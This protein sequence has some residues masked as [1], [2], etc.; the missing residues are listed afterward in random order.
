[1][2][3]FKSAYTA[4]KKPKYKLHYF[5]L[6]VRADAIRALLSTA[7]ADWEDITYGDDW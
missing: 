2:K 1:M 5:G 7:N 4:T 6:H 3:F